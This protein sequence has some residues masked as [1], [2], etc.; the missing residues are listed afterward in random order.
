MHTG[1]NVRAK[2][3]DGHASDSYF[4][5]S[6]ANHYAS[7]KLHHEVFD[8]CLPFG[9]LQLRKV[10]GQYLKLERA[11]RPELGITPATVDGMFDHPAGDIAKHVYDRQPR[12]AMGDLLA[13]VC[14]EFY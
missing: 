6:I 14:G 1:K 13:E 9:S 2:R 10:M 5:P 12:N 4:F 7:T 8:K 11:R 3:F